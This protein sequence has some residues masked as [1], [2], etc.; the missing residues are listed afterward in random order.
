MGGCDVAAQG[1]FKCADLENASDAESVATASDAECNSQGKADSD[2]VEECESEA[3]SDGVEEGVDEHV[4]AASTVSLTLSQVPCTGRARRSSASIDKTGNQRPTETADDEYD[5]DATSPPSTTAAASAAASSAA[6][7]TPT[8]TCTCTPTL[9]P[10][11]IASTSLTATPTR[12]LRSRE[13]DPYLH[14]E[15]DEE[16]ALNTSNSTC[17]SPC[18]TQCMV[19]ES[20]QARADAEAS[21]AEIVPGGDSSVWPSKMR[22]PATVEPTLT[23]SSAMVETTTVGGIHGGPYCGLVGANGAGRQGEASEE[24]DQEMEDRKNVSRMRCFV[25]TTHYSVCRLANDL[26]I[27][28]HIWVRSRP[29][30]LIRV[31]VPILIPILILILILIPIPIPI[32][33]PKSIPIQKPILIPINIYTKNL[34]VC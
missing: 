26:E 27:R 11:P 22:P 23:P 5:D 28:V 24:Y 18:R 3:G 13:F 6:T 34:V 15:E 30:A 7:A 32:P 31:R 17:G 20:T 29:C 12:N 33:I 25:R 4:K 21:T 19:G 10:T 8:A 2:V 9:T 16:D 1:T 14:V